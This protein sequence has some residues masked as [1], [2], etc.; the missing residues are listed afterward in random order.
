MAESNLNQKS[1]ERN[2]SVSPN[3]S[4]APVLYFLS[5]SDS[6]PESSFRRYSFTGA[7]HSQKSKGRFS[8][9][10][11]PIELSQHTPEISINIDYN[12]EKTDHHV[13]RLPLDLFICAIFTLE[14]VGKLYASVDRIRFVFRFWNIIDLLSIIPFYL[15]LIIPITT[16]ITTRVF[17]LSLVQIAMMSIWVFTI[18]ITSST[19]MYY[20]ERGDFNHDDL[21]WYRAGSDGQVEPSPYQSIIHSFWWSVVTITTTGYGDAVPITGWGKFIAGITMLCGILLIAIPTSIIGSNYVNEWALYRR[22]EFQE[23]L[24]KTRERANETIA[25]TGG[26]TK[27]IEILRNQNQTMLEA[28]AEIQE[29]LTDINPPRYWQKYK[30]L[31][32]DYENA[33]IRIS[34]L[35]KDVS[36]WKRIAENLDRFNGKIFPGSRKYDEMKNVDGEF[37]GAGKCEQKNS[38]DDGL[39]IS[40]KMWEK[41]KPIRYNT[42][43]EVRNYSDQ[44]MKSQKEN[45]SKSKKPAKGT[46]RFY[47]K[48]PLGRRKE[49]HNESSPHSIDKAN[50]GSP[51]DLY[52]NSNPIIPDENSSINLNETNKMLSENN[53][54]SEDN[55]QSI[56]TFPRRVRDLKRANTTILPRQY[57]VEKNKTYNSPLDLFKNETEKREPVALNAKNLDKSDSKTSLD[58]DTRTTLTNIPTISVSPKQPS[59]LKIMTQHQI[60]NSGLEAASENAKNEERLEH[61]KPTYVKFLSESPTD[62]SKSHDFNSAT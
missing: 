25:F 51:I 2:T 57:M 23:R 42:T 56:M 55:L 16:G 10:E 32:K 11:T 45:N 1:P 21:T 6:H 9:R 43:S 31:Q 35:E 30:T 38:R 62:E 33:L 39:H 19:I 48:L 24:R 34:H 52:S 40:G 17:K 47:I 4:L 14:Y 58:A 36:K 53:S 22:I 41:L 29:K 44:E 12:N 3:P 8:K 27:Q 18:V 61:N 5:S 60:D 46:S 50:I 20:L 7:P 26:K 28:L 37:G 15:D 49:P 13:D 59:L 54:D